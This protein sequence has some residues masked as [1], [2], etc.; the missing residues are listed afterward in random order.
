MKRST[1]RTFLRG[2]ALA[3]A[4]VAANQGCI[5]GCFGHCET[6]Y[7]WVADMGYAE[8]GGAG[9]G[10]PLSSGECQR[11]CADNSYVTGCTVELSDAGGRLVRCKA[12]QPCEGGRRPAGL[13]P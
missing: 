10:E 1:L 13:T 4:P 2:L 8:D 5:P 7:E 3:A 9:P 12:Y 6:D 11:Y